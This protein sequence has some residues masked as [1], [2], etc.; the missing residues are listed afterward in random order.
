MNKYFTTGEYIFLSIGIVL[1]FWI[2]SL[3]ASVQ[4]NP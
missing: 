4:I 1:G 2:V 3:L